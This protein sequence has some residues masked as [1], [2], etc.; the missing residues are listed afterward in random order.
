MPARVFTD[1]ERLAIVTFREAKTRLGAEMTEAM[2]PAQDAYLQKKAPLMKER[3]AAIEVIA[4][5]EA[6]LKE[7]A[8]ERNAINR[9]IDEEYGL[10]SHALRDALEKAGVSEAEAASEEV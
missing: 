5:V 6:R 3:E 7:L 9:P 2:A 8:A 1:K 4:R 10:R